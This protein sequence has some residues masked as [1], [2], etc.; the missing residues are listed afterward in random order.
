MSAVNVDPNPTDGGLVELDLDALL[1]SLEFDGTVPT[2]GEAAALVTAV[3]AHLT[4]RRI[5]AAEASSAAEPET[6]PEWKLASR[7]EKRGVYPRRRPRNVERGT[8][9]RTASRSL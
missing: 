7:F 1:A 8:E 5:A 4:D 3:G 2:D 6:V 9:W